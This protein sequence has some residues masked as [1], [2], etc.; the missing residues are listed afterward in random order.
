MVNAL[1]AIDVWRKDFDRTTDEM[2][3]GFTRL[4]TGGF[5]WRRLVRVLAAKFV[6][7]ETVILSEDGLLRRFGIDL[8]C[9]Q[10]FQ[11]LDSLLELLVLFAELLVLLSQ[12]SEESFQLSNLQSL[13]IDLW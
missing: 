1:I 13:R 8:G 9:Q 3:F 10:G 4:S 11:S 6:A 7:I 12:L 5:L 2:L